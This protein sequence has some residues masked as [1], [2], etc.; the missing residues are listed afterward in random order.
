VRVRGEAPAEESTPTRLNWG[1]GE[2]L[3]AGWINSDVKDEPGVDLVADIRRGLP[4]ADDSI[5]CAASVHAL[6]ELAF[7]DQLPALRELLR[8]LRPDG[9]LRLVLPDFDRAIDAYRAGHDGYFDVPAGEARSAGGRFLAHSLW[10][11]YT[12]TLFTAD[13]VAELLVRAGFDRVEACPFGR[14][15]SPFGGI[16]GLDNRPAESMCLEGRKPRAGSRPLIVPYNPRVTGDGFEIIDVAADPGE[17]VRGHFQVRDHE[18]GKLEIIGWALGREIAAT[19]VVVVADGAVAGSAPVAV[20]RPDV[21]EKFPDVAE[22]P[23]SGFRLELLAK[24]RGESQLDV[25]A[26]LKDES[27]EPLGRIVVK[28]S[29]RGLF[30]AFRRG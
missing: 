3:G 22:A 10:F 23:T 16:V 27:R 25:Y 18:D 15:A 1:C 8:V 4:L 9:A 24:G 2:H 19:E 5:D 14:T 11:G 26:V 7:G 6:P 21:A 28:T 30:D 29:R 13:F 20:D 12:R 17:R